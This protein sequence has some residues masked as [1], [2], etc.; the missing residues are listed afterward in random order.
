MVPPATSPV[1]VIVLELA[2][3]TGAWVLL[4]NVTKTISSGSSLEICLRAT[5]SDCGCDGGRRAIPPHFWLGF[6]GHGA[7]QAESGYVTYSSPDS[8]SNSGEKE[9]SEQKHCLLRRNMYHVSFQY[10]CTPAQT[11]LI[12]CKGDCTLGIFCCIGN[13]THASLI[14]EEN[15][16]D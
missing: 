9:K 1:V 2:T 6:P 7:E 11:I 5:S 12:C 15:G 8:D 13:R 16:Y 10:P 3:S 14:V 4:Y